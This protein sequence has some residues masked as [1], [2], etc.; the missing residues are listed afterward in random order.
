MK[1]ITE[2]FAGPNLRVKRSYKQQRGWV[3]LRRLHLSNANFDTRTKQISTH[4]HINLVSSLLQSKHDS[5]SSLISFPILKSKSMYVAEDL[6]LVKATAH[7]SL[8]TWQENVWACSSSLL[9]AL[10]AASLHVSVYTAWVS[11]QISL[12][13]LFE[14]VLEIT[15]CHFTPRHVTQNERWTS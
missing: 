8:A 7:V 13:N 1:K 10:H 15:G 4:A 2:S 12:Q 6:T 9:F 3:N 5:F 14:R 11:W